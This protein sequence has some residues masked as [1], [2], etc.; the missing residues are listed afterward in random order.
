MEF[1]FKY[2][3]SEEIAKSVETAAVFVKTSR[4][5]VMTTADTSVLVGRVI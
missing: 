2:S 1:K 5:V 3:H 4:I